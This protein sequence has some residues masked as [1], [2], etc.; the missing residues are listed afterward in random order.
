MKELI[1][2]MSDGIS[3]YSFIRHPEGKPVGHIHILH[4]MA[5]HIGRYDSTIDFFVERGYVVSGHDHRGHG[6][7][8]QLNGMRGHFADKDGFN[9][10]VEDVFEVITHMKTYQDSLKFILIGHSMGSFVARRFIQLHGGIIDLV[11]LSGT[12]DDS[13]I[14]RYA[15]QATAYALGKKDG[16][17]RQNKLLNS[18]VFGEFNRSVLNPTTQFDWISKNE[19]H[20]SSYL[21]DEHCG[22]IP[23]TQFFVDLFAGLGVIHSKKEIARIPKSLPILLFAGTEDPVGRNGNALWKVAKQYD[24]THIED[25]TVQLFEGGRHEL[26]NDSTRPEVVQAV[27]EWIEQR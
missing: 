3:V 23:T 8:A 14:A 26:L 6:K 21:A 27:Q 7:T 1:L 13:G 4:G 17:Q 25:V 15:G 16:F 18:L 2:N 12:G 9:R 22:F 5:E 11:V 19:A 24:A 10:V 20:V